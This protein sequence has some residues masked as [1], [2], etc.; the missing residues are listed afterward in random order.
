MCLTDGN[1]LSDKEET[2]SYPA[3]IDQLDALLKREMGVGV[4]HVKIDYRRLY[5]RGISLLKALEEC[6]VVYR[7]HNT[8]A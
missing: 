4:E 8:A 7:A 2:M 1:Q 6:R 3:W 5:N